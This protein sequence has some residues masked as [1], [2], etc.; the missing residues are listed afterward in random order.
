MLRLQIE[1][2]RLYVYTDLCVYNY[3]RE[4]KNQD[5]NLGTQTK[6]LTYLHA[7][8]E[9]F[10]RTACGVP[11]CPFHI[12]FVFHFLNKPMLACLALLCSMSWWLAGLGV[13][14]SEG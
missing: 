1:R 5:Y 6:I 2:C 13:K 8:L 10:H 14:Q 3:E 4:I 7:L 9:M 11:F 12:F